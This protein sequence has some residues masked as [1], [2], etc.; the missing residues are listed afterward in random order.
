MRLRE[1]PEQRP[2]GRP[3]GT[4]LQWFHLA[5]E[6]VGFGEAMGGRGGVAHGS[7]RFLE[8]VLKFLMSWPLFFILLPTFHFS[9]RVVG[10]MGGFRQGCGMVRHM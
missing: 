10:A 6:V 4:G 3:L 5:G 2:G 9:M 7:S 1:Q 8:R